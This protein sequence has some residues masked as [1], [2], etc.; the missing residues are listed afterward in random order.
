[1]N[2]I[3]FLEKIMGIIAFIGIVLVLLLICLLLFG[4]KKTVCKYWQKD[5]MTN[6]MSCY[7]YTTLYSF[8]RED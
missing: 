2:N 7:K 6:E 3:E 4:N 8:E 1:M 5:E